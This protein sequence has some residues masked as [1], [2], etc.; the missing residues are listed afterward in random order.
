MKSDSKSQIK[1]DESEGVKAGKSKKKKKVESVRLCVN[2][3]SDDTSED[4]LKTAF[5]VHG[6]VRDVY[7]PG[8]GFAFVTFATVEEAKAAKNA[9]NGQ[10]V[11]GKEIECNYAKYSQRVLK[12]V[13]KWRGGS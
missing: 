13:Q 6:T 1:L 2:N 9:M 4:D 10:K 11:C 7:N 5:S 3:V 12:K 8:K